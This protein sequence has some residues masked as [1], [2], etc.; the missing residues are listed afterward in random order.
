MQGNIS[1]QVMVEVKLVLEPGNYEIYTNTTLTWL[2]NRTS[3]M[4]VKVEHR[5]T[6]PVTRYSN[7]P[8]TR[9]R[10]HYVGGN[11]DGTDMSAKMI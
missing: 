6:Q 8:T 4:Q 9:E 7:Q 1:T 5:K 11:K 2:R 10:V 3:S